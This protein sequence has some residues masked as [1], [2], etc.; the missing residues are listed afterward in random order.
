[1]AADPFSGPPPSTTQNVA[2]L[3]VY[4]STPP[5]QIP[6]FGTQMS[7]T[8]QGAGRAAGNVARLASPLGRILDYQRWALAKKL[9]GET[10]PDKQLAAIRR[11]WP[12]MFI[13]QEQYEKLPDYQKPI[14]DAAESA[15]LDPLTIETALV[16]AAARGAYGVARAAAPTLAKVVARA[17]EGVQDVVKAA[18]IAYRKGKRFFT[19]GTKAE[20]ALSKVDRQNLQGATAEMQAEADEIKK[21]L[22][23][24]QE[25]ALKPLTEDE[26][27]G[28]MMALNGEIIPEFELTPAARKAYATI[29]HLTDSTEYLQSDPLHRQ[30]I[31]QRHGGAFHPPENL[32]QFE[33][34]HGTMSPSQHRENYL[35]SPREPMKKGQPHPTGSYNWLNYEN[36]NWRERE[37]FK[38]DPARG[39]QPYID[40][41][42]SSYE[43][44]ARQIAA[45]RVAA[46]LR[47]IYGGLIP[48]NVQAAAARPVRARGDQRTEGEILE[49]VYKG[50]L[51]YGRAAQVS[52]TPY[53]A[54]ANVGGLTL[55]HDPSGATLGRVLGKL[56]KALAAKPDALYD[57][58]KLGRILGA[59]APFAEHAAPF[60][61]VPLLGPWAK[62]MSKVTWTAD[63]LA[64]QELARTNL[65]KQQG[66]FMRGVESQLRKAG[67]DAKSA[68]E[69]AENLGAAR[70]GYGPGRMAR[71]D[72]ID[73]ANPSEFG[74]LISW[75]SKFPNYRSQLIP[76]VLR[77]V[78]KNPA[79]VEA[80]NRATSGVFLGGKANTPAGEVDYYGGPGEVGRL[81]PFQYTRGTFADP[82]RGAISATGDLASALRHPTV[83]KGL[84]YMTYGRSPIPHRDAQGHWKNWQFGAGMLGA[85]F[86]FERPIQTELGGGLFKPTGAGNEALFATT[87]VSVR[88]KQPR[89]KAK[90]PARIQDPFAGAPPSIAP[91]PVDPF[92]GAPPTH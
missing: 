72:L 2:P 82:V 54:V 71:E 88:P 76:S 47:G 25:A 86:P 61:G 89:A 49:D 45:D 53:H 91:G 75:V 30:L 79:G 83:S 85:G 10:D 12:G 4:T 46:K 80:V 74:R 14:E 19:P 17:P 43:N 23:A 59:D 41:L 56:P 48:E 34:G 64:A 33:H 28:V 26:K 6:S 50:G 42:N 57:Q 44:A 81:D 73:Y 7:R 5:P 16:G 11:K 58:M 66:H 1:M 70:A 68:R 15:A 24:H 20:T 3:P 84:H 63:R 65:W 67:L 60:Q 32:K 8:A 36:P 21:R 13:T 18:G 77:A 78:A 27:I 37:A 9:T 55:A 31:E 90:P 87:G 62:G 39:S 22:V 92:A 38:V 40:A 51:G 29:R 52:L 69:A 35:P